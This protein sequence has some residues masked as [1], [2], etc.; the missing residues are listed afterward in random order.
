ME[1]ADRLLPILVHCTIWS[2]L[3][4]G[5]NAV[6]LSDIYRY[7]VDVEHWIDGKQFVAAFAMSQALPGPNSMAATLIACQAAGIPGALLAVIATIVPTSVLAYAGASWHEARRDA[8]LVRLIRNALM[9][10]TVGLILASTF[11]LAREIDTSLLKFALTFGASAMVLWTRWNPIWLIVGG[12]G[13]G[14]VSGI[15][16][17]GWF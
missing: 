14:G 8:P 6:A 7:T 13:L 10:V 17:F 3:A 4:I 16:G 9:P 1:H 5:G 2:L 15:F 12:I 11:V